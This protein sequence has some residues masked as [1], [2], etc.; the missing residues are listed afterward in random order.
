MCRPPAGSGLTVTSAVTSSANGVP[1]A[2]AKTA[3]NC[4][5]KQEECAAAMSSSG[6]VPSALSAIR[7]GKV[8][9]KMPAWELVSSTC[10]VPSIS[11]PVQAVRAV[12]VAIDLSLSVR[13]LQRCSEEPVNTTDR[14]LACVSSQRPVVF[15]ALEPRFLAIHLLAV[16][17]VAFAGWLGA[18]QYSAWQADREAQSRSFEDV[19]PVPLDEVMG[20][21]DAFPGVDNGRPVDVQGEWLPEATISVSGRLNPDGG[22]DEV[23]YW[24]VTPVVIGGGDGAAFPVVRGWT[25]DPEAAASPT[26]PADL[27]AWLQAPEGGGEPDDDPLDNIVPTLRVAEVVQRL[28]RDAYGGFGIAVEPTAGLESISA[29]ASAGADWSTGLRNLL[30]AFEWW[31]FGGFAVFAWWRYLRD[32]LA[33]SEG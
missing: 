29:A 22:S 17:L 30:Y 18:W 5:A 7:L 8:T 6:V 23:G 15:R 4:I 13:E 25:A 9:S 20:P 33:E 26:G 10:P 32:E 28:E 31:F 2:S 19:V 16:A 21:D 3:E 27:V 14:R 11:P 1:P 12:R 24:V